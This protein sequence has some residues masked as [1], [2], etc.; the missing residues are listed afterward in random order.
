MHDNDYIETSVVRRRR[1]APVKAEQ[2]A[3]GISGMDL[4]SQMGNRAFVR[5]V[6]GSTAGASSSPV[7][8]AA[9]R[10]QGAG[11]LDS[12]IEAD[13]RGAQGG[14]RPLDDHVRGDMESHLGTDLSAVRVH[15]DSRGDALSRSVQADAF[16]T[17][18]D[19]FF[20]SGKYSPDSG[21][22]RKLLAHELTHVVQQA[23][24]TVPTESRISH[25]DDAHEREAAAVADTVASVAP[26]TSPTGADATGGPAVQR[27]EAADEELEDEEGAVS[28]QAAEEEELEEEPESM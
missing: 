22:G 23:S 15:A 11:P 24:G 16:T 5:H 2:P 7:Q 10:S 19:V 28:R 26:V 1:V 13:I 12:E 14:G 4:P 18:T 3:A 6:A 8:R 9:T 25:P 17:G 27:E 20:R 21:D